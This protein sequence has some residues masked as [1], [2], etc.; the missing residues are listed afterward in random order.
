MQREREM[1]TRNPTLQRALDALRAICQESPEITGNCPAEAVDVDPLDDLWQPFVEWF[2]R[3]VW[4]DAEAVARCTANPR[5]CAAVA[6]LYADFCHW[7]FDRNQAPVTR[8]QFTNL[9][10]EFCLDVRVIAGEQLVP[11][12]AFKEN[13]FNDGYPQNPQEFPEVR[14][15]SG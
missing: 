3:R 1:E 7:M 4:L 14:R 13:V 9:L 12:V 6:A 8:E 5:W 2:D 10:R 15:E 11:N